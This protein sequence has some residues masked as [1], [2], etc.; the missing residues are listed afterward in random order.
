MSCDPIW[1]QACIKSG[2]SSGEGVI[3][4]I[5]DPQGQDPGVSDKRLLVVESEFAATLRVMARDGNTLSATI[6]QAW[7]G[8]TL[9]VLT[10]QFPERATEPHVS[11]IGH[12]CKDE[13][14]RELTRTDAANGFGNRFLWAAVRRSKALPDG[15]NLPEADLLRLQKRVTCAVEWARALGDH[16]LKR[17]SEARALWHK[18]YFDLSEGK[19]GLFGAVTSRAEAQV[20]RLA[21]VYALLDQSVVIKREH[22]GAALAVWRYCEVSARYVFGDA[23]GDPLADEILSN[24]RAAG[25]SGLTRTDLNNSFK[26]NREA[27]DIS[28]RLGFLRDW[29]LADFK[30]ERTPGRSAERWY[31]I[32]FLPGAAG[33]SSSNS[34][35]SYSAGTS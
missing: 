15:G 22:L 8:N 21:C 35:N 24:L 30:T 31:A 4:A 13:L 28:Q 19:P 23:T 6:R 7:D 25:R 34:F 27:A 5:R 1:E 26:R 32:E 3:H 14:R 17:D 16:E 29:R 9:Q 12:I 11:I 18:V 33:L 2:L 20:M 10:K